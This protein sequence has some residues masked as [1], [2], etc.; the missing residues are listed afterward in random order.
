MMI[1]V[2]MFH[3]LGFANSN[4]LLWL[5]SF[6]VAGSGKQMRKLLGAH[7]ERFEDRFIDQITNQ[8]KFPV[9]SSE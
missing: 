9:K 6:L 8:L 5:S 4:L 1:P 2:H 7:Q 3:I